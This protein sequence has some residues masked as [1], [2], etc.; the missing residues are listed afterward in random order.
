MTYFLQCYFYLQVNITIEDINDNPPVFSNIRVSTS[1]SEDITHLTT[2]YSAHAT[3]KDSRANGNGEVKYRLGETFNN[4]FSID[5]TSGE[6]RLSVGAKLNYEDRQ[7]YELTIIAHD[8]GQSVQRSSTMTLVINVQDSNDNPPVFAH[9]AFATYISEAAAV[10]SSITQITADDKDKG[11]NGRITFSVVESE[12][13]EYFGIFPSDGVLYLKKVLDR[14]VKSQYVIQ[15]KARDHGLPS[16]S[17]TAQV[18]IYVEDYNDNKPQIAESSYQFSIEENLPSD[19]SVGR[20]LATDADE[21]N[22][23]LLQYDLVP[24]QDKFYITSTGV[25]LTTK[26]LDRE[27]KDTFDFEVRVQ[28]SGSPPQHSVV[29]VHITVSDVNDHTPTIM[30]SQFSERVDENQPKGIR[31]VQIVAQDLDAG[32]NGTISFSLYPGKHNKYP[33]RKPSFVPAKSGRNSERP[34]IAG[35][36][37]LLWK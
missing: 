29:P 34:R 36:N 10:S 16:L 25:I 26:S 6:V 28:D 1:V 24:P 23:A 30:N 18:T 2:I 13:S 5:S 17:A 27:L 32:E 8:Q 7:Q 14:E 35:Q 20:I 31:V 4:L 15:V 19:T 37:R 33:V 3:D 12:F 22:N 11:E 21:G 9:S